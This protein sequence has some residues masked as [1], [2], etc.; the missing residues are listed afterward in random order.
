[1]TFDE[2]MSLIR[3]SRRKDWNVIPCWGAGSGP[4]YRDKFEISAH[5]GKPPSW[6]LEVHSHGMVAV[7]KCD[8]SVSIAWGLTSNESFTEDWANSFPDPHASSSY[9]DFFHCGALIHR[10]LYVTVDGGRVSLPLPDREEER[11][12]APRAYVELCRLL[13]SFESAYDEDFDR[14]V[15]NAGINVIERPWP[16]P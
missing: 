9:V 11:L 12:V 15:S 13:V 2:Y 14:Y 1:M 8:I 5:M 6:E 7:L 4:S 10:E 3:N 16:I